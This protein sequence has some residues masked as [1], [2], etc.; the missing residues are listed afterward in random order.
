M[1]ALERFADDGSAAVV[2]RGLDEQSAGVG[3]AG[4][5]DRPEPALLA[6]GVFGGND[7]EVGGELVGMIKAPPLADLCA[8]PDRGQCVDPRAGTEAGRLCARTAR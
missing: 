2:V 1:A 7:P 3:G 4:L 5:G 6:G 8:Q